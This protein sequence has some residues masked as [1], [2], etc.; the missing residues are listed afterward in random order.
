[1]RHLIITLLLS[2]TVFNAKAQT[3]V[4]PDANFEQA[5]INQGLDSGSI[6]GTV[7]TS[8]INTLDTLYVSSQS[9]SDLTGIEDFVA[10]KYFVCHGNQLT[11][12]D[13]TNNIALTA[14]FCDNNQLTNINISNN[15]ALAFLTCI[16]NQL[17]S[18]DLTNNIALRV[19]S[20]RNNQLTSLDI[21]NNTN[22]VHLE[23]NDNQLNCM[24]VKNGNN[25]NFS[26]CWAYN[27][28]N[29]TC[30]EVDDDSYSTT[31]WSGFSFNFDTQTSFSTNCNNPCSIGVGIEENNL[32]NL[33][34]YPNPTQGNITIDLGES[35][36]N[37]KTTL[38]NSLGQVIET[39][40]YSSTNFIEMNIN[41]PKG[42]YF[43]QIETDK[44]NVITK[45]IFK[46]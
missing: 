15:T 2:L 10:L 7:P 33:S 1:M 31:N 14:L 32:S 39:K 29:L 16:H 3:T 43:L 9:I 5:L 21:T 28:P 45:K 26:R 44:G 12:L 11:N 25:T 40:N 41:A 30:L 17:T 27:N 35:T 42:L 37:L 36:S 13:V 46:N 8:N 22:L 19:L 23:C 6:D 24:N 20:C 34:I 18:L 38:I 4:I